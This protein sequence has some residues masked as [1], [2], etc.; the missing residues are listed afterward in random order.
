MDLLYINE[1][2]FT[3]EEV[4]EITKKYLKFPNREKKIILILIFLLLDYLLFRQIDP[5]TLSFYSVL[6]Y[7]GL[8]FGGLSLGCVLFFPYIKLVLLVLAKK[9]TAS[10]RR[11][12]A[13]SRFIP[14]G[15][16]LFY[17]N[18]IINEFVLFDDFEEIIE[19][20]DK[21]YLYSDITN[22]RKEDEGKLWIVYF[23][24]YFFIIH[25]RDFIQGQPNDFEKFINS[26]I[27]VNS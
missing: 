24:N 13:G 19:V 23:G 12:W 16:I 25:K 6:F 14:R 27:T 15:R 7:F 18:Y 3:E 9:M 26:K 20:K 1:Q 5:F 21:K 2:R 17:E 22:L 10:K 8:I 11:K 4:K